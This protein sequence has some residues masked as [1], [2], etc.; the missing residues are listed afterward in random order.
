MMLCKK[1][2]RD[3]LPVTGPYLAYTRT[4]F[5]ASAKFSNGPST[6]MFVFV[7]I[8]VLPVRLGLVFFAVISY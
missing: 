1:D 7:L 6:R 8:R 4:A 2:N 5:W 3:G